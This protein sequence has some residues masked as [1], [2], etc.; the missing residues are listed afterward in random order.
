MLWTETASDAPP[1]I[2]EGAW[3]APA[4]PPR[5]RAGRQTLLTSS[6]CPEPVIGLSHGVQLFQQAGKLSL[7]LL[8]QATPVQK[9]CNG[10]ILISSRCVRVRPN[11]QQSPTHHSG[12]C[13]HQTLHC[14]QRLMMIEERNHLLA[15]RNMT[16]RHRWA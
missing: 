11:L 13:Q 2:R 10:T 9:C 8:L 15:Q 6:S 14:A 5:Y 12:H 3:R 7:E 16:H 1:W 4:A